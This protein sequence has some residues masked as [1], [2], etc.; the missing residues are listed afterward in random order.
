MNVDSTNFLQDFPQDGKIYLNNASVS[1]MPL[2]SIEAM[3]K[4]LINY[5]IKGPDS[6]DSDIFL[7][8]KLVRIRK[9]ISNLIHCKPEEIV[10]TQSTTDGVNIVAN[11]LSVD[12]KSNVVIRGMAHEHHAN[13]YP[14]L[15]LS[16]K[17]SLKSL[18]IDLNGFFDIKELRKLVDKNTKCVALSHA[19]YNTGAILPV[20]EIGDYLE[21]NNVPYFIDAAQTVGCIGDYDFKKTK[22]NFM[23]FN[24][25]KWLCGPMGTGIFYCKKESSKLLEPSSIGG[26]SAMVYDETSLAYK[27]IPDKFQTGFRNYVGFVGLEESINYML[28]FGLNNIHNKIMNLSN[29]MREELTKISGITLFGPEDQSKR[30]SIVSFSIDDQ[31]PQKIVELLEKKK[32]V[33]AVREIVDKKI[34]RASP[35]FFNSEEEIQKIVDEIRKL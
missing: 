30:T 31:K 26:E 2:S 12:S 1:L 24:G 23:S 16:Q 14:W 10:F 35:H 11:G 17:L 28:Q 27:D 7:K 22:S 15:R 3:K 4:F 33:I 13:Y 18:K 8:E 19:L 25:S 20:E 34:L 5:S 6:I 21:K 32:I 29:Q 9:T